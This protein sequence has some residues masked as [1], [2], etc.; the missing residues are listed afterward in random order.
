MKTRVQEI[1][2]ILKSLGAPKAQCN[3]RSAL[4]LLGLLDLDPLVP[5]QDA[6]NPQRGVTE[7]MDWMATTYLK[8]YAPNTRET[9]RRFTLHQFMAMGLVILNPDDPARSPNSPKNVYQIAPSALRLLQSYGTSTWDANLALY[10]KSSKS[11]NRLRARTRTLA[12]IPITLPHGETITLSAGG[13]NVLIK[14]IVDEFAKRFTPGGRLIYLGD[15]AE[16]HAYFDK[17]VLHQLGVTVDPHGKMPDG[18]LY[19]A[20]RNWLILIEAVTSHGPVNP[21]RHAQLADLFAESTAGLVFVTAFLDRSTM[22]EYLP[23]IAWE[24]EVWV[25]D[26]PDHLIH[27]DGER[28]LGPY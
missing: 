5:W 20:K 4:T 15:A 13:Q 27:F 18:I 16:K 28:F 17:D 12:H 11:E 23:E 8:Q 22:R 25:A 14:E 26:A 10:V 21:L 24:T 7:L 9:I 19:D 1:I 6:T 3:D 2:D